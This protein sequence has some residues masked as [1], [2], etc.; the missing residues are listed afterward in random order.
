MK[1]TYLEMCN[2]D[3]YWWIGLTCV[4]SKR[5]GSQTEILSKAHVSEL[6]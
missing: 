2:R 6:Y 3:N 1:L 5:Y 4:N